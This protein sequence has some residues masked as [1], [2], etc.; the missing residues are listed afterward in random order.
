MLAR[1]IGAITW[2]RIL[3]WCGLVVFL[4]LAIFKKNPDPTVLFGLLAM[5]GLPT[6]LGLDRM[7]QSGSGNGSNRASKRH[8]PESDDWSE[9]E[10]H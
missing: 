2:P 9:E 6:F 8:P 1:I 7:A 3:R 10:P 4:Y 5:M